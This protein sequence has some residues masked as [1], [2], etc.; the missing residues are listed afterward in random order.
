MFCFGLILLVYHRHI[1]SNRLFLLI[2]L[3]IFV[4]VSCAVYIFQLVLLM[5]GHPRLIHRFIYGTVGKTESS[6]AP[7]LFIVYVIY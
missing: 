3:G 6:S 2:E 1:E 4:Y 5:L 7:S